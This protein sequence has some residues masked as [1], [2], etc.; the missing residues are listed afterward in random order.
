[1]EKFKVNLPLKAWAEEDKPREKLIMKGRQALSEAELIAILISTGNRNET[2]VELSKRIMV[3]VQNNLNELSRLSLNDLMKFDGIGKAKAI[4]IL[5]AL[6]IGRRRKE[7]VFRKKEKIISSQQA[8]LYLKQMLSDLPHEEFWV[9]LLD[10]SNQI[11]KRAMI[12]RGGVSG[13]VVDSKIIFKSAIETLASSMIL[14]HNHPSGNTKP[15]EQDIQITRK[16]KEA[17][18]TMEIPVIDH[19]IV[20]ENG[21]YSFADEGT[22]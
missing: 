12:S 19:L 13:T 18:K 3:S 7:T 11:I 6:E 2:S 16:I 4:C 20:C 1:M 21:Y 9:I 15:S 8:Y 10:R 17:G 22:L 5:A 14:G